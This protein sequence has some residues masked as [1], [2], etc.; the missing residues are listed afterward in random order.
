M[1]TVVVMCGGRGLRLHPITEKTPKPMLRV[2]AKPM[3]ETIITR[4]A[5]QG[6][7]EFVFCVNYLGHLIRSYFGDGDKWG[8]S[9]RYVE[10]EHPLGT[11]GALALIPPEWL[12]SP[13]IVTNGDVL[14]DISYKNLL[15]THERQGADATAALALH[16]QQIHFGVC[17]VDGDTIT[18]IREKPIEDF[19]V[20]AGIY[21]LNRDEVSRHLD[22]GATAPLDMPDLIGMLRQVAAH[23][24]EGYWH[25]VGTFESMVRANQEV[26]L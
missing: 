22:V 5:D 10:E 4:F 20:L 16:Q 14:A 2:G 18:N 11:A 1:T 6:F 9:I 13:Y 26:S 24:I 3:L 21:V 23:P 8:L 19:L 12:T 15:A 17:H 7:R 25:D